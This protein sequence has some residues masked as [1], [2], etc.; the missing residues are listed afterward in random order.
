VAVVD[1]AGVVL[2]T[3]QSLRILKLLATQL[4]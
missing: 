4:N 1:S 2:T 3:P